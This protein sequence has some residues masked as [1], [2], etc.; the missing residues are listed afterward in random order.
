[1]LTTLVAFTIVLGILIFFH[2][3]GHF[4]LAKANGVGVLKFSLGFG[5]ALIKKRLGE[6]EYRIA[7]IPLGGYVK[8]LGEDQGEDEGPSPIAPER[9]FNAKGLGAKASIVAAGPVFNFLLAIAIYILIA[10]IGIPSFVAVVGQVQD[11][12]PAQAAG[13]LPGDRI[14]AIAGDKVAVWDDI[15]VLLQRCPAGKPVEIEI[16]RKG[17]SLTLPV[18][19][20]LTPDKDLFGEEIQR[21]MIGIIRT[22]ATITHRLGLVQGYGFRQSLWIVKLTGVGFWKIINGSLDI[23]KSLGGPIM[24]AD[25]SGQTFKAGWLPFF[26]LIAF[27]S[28]NLGLI[29]LLPIPVLDGGYLLFFLIE[30]ITG[31]PVE[32]RPREIAQQIGLFLLVLL[33]LLAFYNDIAR[34]ITGG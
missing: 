17:T 19:P 2:E 1:M 30:A 4:L 34:L 8:M 18:S 15:A 14:C 33:M 27:I 22:D 31:R 13:I 12:S 29:N 32:G 3:L 16:A 10:W 20:V 11:G 21:V 26:S 25:V 24:I 5:P 23:K 9:S 6:T 28:I 7:A